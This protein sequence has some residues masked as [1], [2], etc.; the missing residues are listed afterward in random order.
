MDKISY[1]EKA[2]KHSSETDIFLKSHLTHL[3]ALMSSYL[4]VFDQLFFFGSLTTHSAV[5]LSPDFKKGTL[6]TCTP[7]EK[8]Q[9]CIITIY[10]IREITFEERVRSY[11]STLLHEMI[12][13]YFQV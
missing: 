5:V 2:V 13:A 9:K 12:H 7:D 10:N 1:H 4:R 3:E 11:L 8:S 6:G